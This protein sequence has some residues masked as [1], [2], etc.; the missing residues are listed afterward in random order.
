[1]RDWFLLEDLEVL[2]LKYHVVFWPSLHRHF[3]LFGKYKLAKVCN[4][5]GIGKGS[6]GFAF[7]LHIVVVP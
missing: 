2:Q 6:V 3:R 1:M 5:Y 7:G 4:R